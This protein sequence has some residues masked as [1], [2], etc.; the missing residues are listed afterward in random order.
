MPDDEKGFNIRGLFLRDEDVPEAKE[1][2]AGAPSVG[3]A[4]L[5]ST[6]STRAPAAVNMTAGPSARALQMLA[7]A[8]EKVPS[9]N[10]QLKLDAA[11]ESIKTLE[12]DTAKRQAMALAML[13]SQGISPEKVSADAIRAREIMSGYLATLDTQ[14][15]ATRATNVEQV[16]ASATDLRGRASAL[17]AEITK[18]RNQQSELNEQASALET[19]AST[20]E[21]NLNAVAADIEAALAII[22]NSAK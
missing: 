7:A 11:M 5:I 4:P 8:Q 22:N 12:P 1:S 16:R 10:A 20:E 14:L 19:K 13:S 9:D 18:I 17:D 21:G 6:L 15:E 2:P 3:A